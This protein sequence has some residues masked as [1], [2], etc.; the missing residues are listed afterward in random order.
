PSI[1]KD[2]GFLFAPNLSQTAS[3]SQRRS[4]RQDA[5]SQQC[6]QV[7]ARALE[8]SRQRAET[9]TPLTLRAVLTPALCNDAGFEQK[10]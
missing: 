10:L 7:Q 2:G 9:E 6:L 4:G 1:R 8:T 3:R 5:A